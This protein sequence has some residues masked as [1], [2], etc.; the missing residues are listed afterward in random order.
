[1]RAA[2]RQAVEKAEVRVEVKAVDSGAADW[3]AVVG[4]L[5]AAAEK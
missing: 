5:A 3:G 1:M 2:L 4:D